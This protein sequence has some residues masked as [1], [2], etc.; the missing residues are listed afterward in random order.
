MIKSLFTL[1]AVSVAL[2]ASAPAFADPLFTINEEY[3]I[4]GAGT[5]SGDKLNGSYTEKLTIKPA[6]NFTTSAYGDFTALVNGTTSVETFLGPLFNDTAA[7]DGSATLG[8][9][10]PYRLY[11]AFD[12]AGAFAPP[13]GFIGGSGNFSIFLDPLRNSEGSLGADGDSPAT[14]INEDDDI[15][16][17]YAN[18]VI[19]GEGNVD[20]PGSFEI[21]WSDFTLTL[22]GQNYF[23]APNPFYLR[24][25][26]DG[27]FDLFEPALSGYEPG[28]EQTFDVRGDVSAV[29]LVPE[30]ASLSLVGLALVGAGLASR[31]RPAKS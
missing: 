2:F 11:F 23:I 16:V 5:Q 1:S 30:P 8:R 28:T 6:G 31:R 27:D 9:D 14:F 21:V 13:S 24:V 18:N 26:V 15:L 19:Y 4:T 25:L 7:G 3:L 10:L 20:N 22:L 12:A 17:A 29:F